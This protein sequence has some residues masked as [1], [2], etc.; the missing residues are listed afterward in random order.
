M[1]FSVKEKIEITADAALCKRCGSC[2][3]VCPSRV[4]RWKDDAIEIVAAGR[5]IGCG[6]CVAACP[7][8]A[9]RHSELPMEGFAPMTGEPAVDAAAVARNLRERRTV[10]RFTQADVTSAEIEVLLDAARYAPTSTN[11][12]NVRF[13]V[14]C[15]REKVGALAE[16]IARY[17]LKLQRQ[18]EN[19]FVR[20]GI[21][22]AVGRKLVNAYRA[23]MPAIAQMFVETLAGDDRLFYGAPAV[24]VLFAPGMPH[25]AAANCGL[26][27]AQI[28]LAAEPQGLGACFNGYA[29]TA[30]IRDKAVR[31]R[32]GISKE[33][34]PGAVVAIGRPAGRFYRVP[35]RQAR[36]V[37]WF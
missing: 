10:R 21:R 25:L 37:I 2:E 33:Y 36:R 27:A 35:P 9:L 26:A 8:A 13:T 17:Y 18:L 3:A 12:Q 31:E 22:I 23:R 16:W 1:V 28:L 6:H 29:L 24:A 15:G 5:C 11:S 7:N 4:F 32:C 34:T 20:T 14:F 19:P 30:L